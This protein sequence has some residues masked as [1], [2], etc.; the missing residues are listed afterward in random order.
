MTTVG[1]LLKERMSNAEGRMTKAEKMTK[2][3]GRNPASGSDFSYSD[4]GLHAA[5]GIRHAS[6]KEAAS[7][8]AELTT[9][10]PRS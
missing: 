3:E 10:L 9:S 5:F 4:F 8:V 7:H 2:P 6:F 1:M